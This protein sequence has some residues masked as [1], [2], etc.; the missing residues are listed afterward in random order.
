MNPLLAR[1]GV[2]LENKLIE[3]AK[4]FVG[5][6]NYELGHRFLPGRSFLP[7]EAAHAA[8]DQLFAALMPRVGGQNLPGFDV[9][10][11]EETCGRAAS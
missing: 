2:V 9:V 4:K 10:V 8:R 1:T 11:N 6:I 3:G 7:E 5:N